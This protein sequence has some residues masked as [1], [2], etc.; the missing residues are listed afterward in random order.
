VNEQV[1]L[2][3]HTSALVDWQEQGCLLTFTDHSLFAG[4][5]LA[6]KKQ[7]AVQLPLPF[8]ENARF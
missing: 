6:V 8:S 1:R 3:V 2:A 5:P 4:R 7:W